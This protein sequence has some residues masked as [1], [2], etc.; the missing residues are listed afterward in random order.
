MGAAPEELAP[1]QPAPAA[2]EFPPSA[3]NNQN[4]PAT[5]AQMKFDLAAQK[6]PE[7][8][9]DAV[10][11]DM[12]EQVR[13]QG[14]EG[15]SWYFFDGLEDMDIYLNTVRPILS[16][17]LGFG[18][19]DQG[20]QILIPSLQNIKKQKVTDDNAI[21]YEDA[22]EFLIYFWNAY[23][24][25]YAQ[26][27]SGKAYVVIPKDRPINQPF[28][29]KKGSW[30]WSFEV[31]ELTR[32]PNV[33]EIY[34]VRIDPTLTI[35]LEGEVYDLDDPV[36]IWRKGDEPIGFPADIRYEAAF[37]SDPFNPEPITL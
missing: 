25:A 36:L 23:S 12:L 22:A 34:V 10:V 13:L 5:T 32:N 14:L 15:S 37:P 31:P 29:D 7:I 8:D 35:T 2:P 6:L 11:R 26:A 24:K 19:D 3:R 30:W 21:R 17:R 33:D 27:V 9:V 28:E 16:K 18:T 4:Q 1:V 20:N